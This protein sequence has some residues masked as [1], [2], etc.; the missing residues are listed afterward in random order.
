[1]SNSG[2]GTGADQKPGQIPGGTSAGGGL[3]NLGS[4]LAGTSVGGILGKGIGELLDQFKQNGHG[5]EAESWIRTGPN[6]EIAPPSVK[7]AIGPE[8]LDALSKQTGLSVDEILKR[9]SRELPAAVDRYTP[10]GR[11]PA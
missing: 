7:E 3:G 1:L 10:D 8:V 2:A 5:S 6:Q 11:V 9:L 4:V